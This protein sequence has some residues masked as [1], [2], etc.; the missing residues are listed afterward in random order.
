MY[1]FLL[2]ESLRPTLLHMTAHSEVTLTL[3]YARIQN[4]NKERKLRNH[5]TALELKFFENTERF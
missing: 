3:L 2:K 4:L 5:C 1:F